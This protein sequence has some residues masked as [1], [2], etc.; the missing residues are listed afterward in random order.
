MATLIKVSGTETEIDLESL[1]QIEEAIGGFFEQIEID[2]DTILL[3]NEDAIAMNLPVN[4][5]ATKLAG[6]VIK[7]NVILAS[8]EEVGS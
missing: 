2:D 4:Q 1:E 6:Q 7:G 3:I 5:K 8:C